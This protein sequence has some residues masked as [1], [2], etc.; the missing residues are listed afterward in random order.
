CGTICTGGKACQA[1]A[2]NCP[3]NQTACGGACTSLSSDPN[4][5]GTCGKACA[6]GQTCQSGTCVGG[7]CPA[8]RQR[9]TADV[10]CAYEGGTCCPASTGGFCC[11]PESPLCCPKERECCTA[12]AACGDVFLCD[13]WDCAPGEFR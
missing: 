8:N 4:N 10:C 11:P 5:C 2:C 1:G 3:A 9:C 13:P 6:A 12:G 7:T